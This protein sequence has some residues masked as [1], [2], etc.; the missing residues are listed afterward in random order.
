MK[1]AEGNGL[2]S[3]VE[4]IYSYFKGDQEFTELIRDLEQFL[5]SSRDGSPEFSTEIDQHFAIAGQLAERISPSPEAR[6]RPLVEGPA[7]KLVVDRNFRIVAQSRSARHAFGD[8]DGLGIE[9][10]G[11][12]RSA[13]PLNPDG[14]GVTPASELIGLLD[15]FVLETIAEIFADRDKDTASTR[16]FVRAGEDGAFVSVTHESEFDVVI[17]T[18]PAANWG[19]NI[20]LM[21]QLCLDLSKSE[22]EILEQ[23]VAGKSNVEISRERSRSLDTVKSQTQSIFRKLGA[24]SRVEAVQIVKDITSLA[25]LSGEAPRSPVSAIRSRDSFPYAHDPSVWRMAERDGRKISWVH[26][27]LPGGR[28]TDKPLVLNFHGLLQSPEL[29]QTARISF[30]RHGYEV[31]GASR[32][33]YGGTDKQPVRS[34]YIETSVEDARMIAERFEGRRIILLGHL[35]GTRIAI[36]YARAHPERVA[37]IVLCSAYF[38]LQ[39]AEHLVPAGAIQK[40]AMSS[41]IASWAAH[42]FIAHTGLSYLRFGG[43]TRYIAALA[44]R[45]TAD[46]NALRDHDIYGLLHAGIRHVTTNGTVGFLGDTG[47]S[48]HDWSDIIA[49]ISVPLFILHGEQDP[50]VNPEIAKLAASLVPHSRIEIVPDAGQQMLHVMPEKVL[51]AFAAV[52]AASEG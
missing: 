14:T 17:V 47:A 42:R 3:A 11:S 26:H 24:S 10:G 46:K 32:P 39:M 15:N 16:R 19:D 36:E 8:L 41:G 23:M 31:A 52:E 20:A 13:L 18:L 12:S 37:G 43:A 51:E 22:V 49:D 30:A 1:E 45:S 38:P 9:L 25:A 5:A 40:L 4:A 2:S 28:D 33:G 35:F 34:D 48:N 6:Y 50:A 29:S 44:E 21:L 27:R 7:L